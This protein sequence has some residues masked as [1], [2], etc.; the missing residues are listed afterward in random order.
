MYWNTMVFI[1]I[2]WL[3]FRALIMFFS[4]LTLLT[5]TGFIKTTLWVGCTCILCHGNF[6]EGESRRFS[7]FCMTQNFGT[8]NW[9][10]ITPRFYLYTTNTFS[11]FSSMFHQL[12]STISHWFLL[13]LG[14][15]GWGAKR[16]KYISRIWGLFWR[17][18]FEGC[19][20]L[21]D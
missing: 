9:V 17:F 4:T 21:P 1:D 12:F 19:L 6:R 14:L 5:K 13:I 15:G 20:L 2:F 7:R 3:A 11:L 10:W 18:W 16:P 8:K